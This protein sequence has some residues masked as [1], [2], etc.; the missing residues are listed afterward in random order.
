M[1]LNV[2]ATDLEFDEK[3]NK[4]YSDGHEI[5][6]SVRQL[7]E[8][9]DVIFNKNFINDKNKDDILYYMFRAAGQY[10]ND[11][12]FQAH[13]MRYDVTVVMPYDLGG[14]FNKTLGHYHP[15][16]NKEEGLSYPELYEV[17]SGDALYL[18][19]K[20]ENDGSYDV[21]LIRARKGDKV[22]MEPNYGHITMNLGKKPLVMANLVNS[23]FKSNY[24]P[25]KEMGGGALFVTNKKKIIY[26]TNYK[27]VSVK[28]LDAPKLDFLNPD[29]SIYDEYIANPEHFIFLNRPEYLLWKQDNWSVKSQMF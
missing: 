14:E 4:L 12:I 8:M 16:C 27:E 2:K 9:K 15:I 22:I 21:K 26:N 19:Q 25:I 6:S 7:S 23:T 28:E 18:L 1:K 3:K 13:N 10:K 5:E 17:I 24:D 11:T 20:Y 29:K